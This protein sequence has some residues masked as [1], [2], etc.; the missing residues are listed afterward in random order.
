MTV[1]PEAPPLGRV[2]NLAPPT[3]EEMATIMRAQAPEEAA[4]PTSGAGMTTADVGQAISKATSAPAPVMPDTTDIVVELPAG[5][6]TPAGLLVDTARCRELN[7]FDEEKLSR[8]DPMKNSAVYVTELLSLGVDDLGGEKP[9]KDVLRSLLIGDRD[10]LMLGVRRATYG[11]EVEFKLACNVC[12]NDSLIKVLIDEDVPVTRLDDPVVREFEVALRNGG[13]AMVRLLNGEAQEAFSGD[14]GKKTQAELTTVMLAKSV[15]AING[16]PVMGRTED[17]LML[18]AA[19]R[20]T[21]TDFIAEHQP[22]PQLNKEIPVSCS[23]CGQEYPVLLGL[24]N[25]FRF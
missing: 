4:P 15:V 20:Q 8:V 2:P 12:D 13:H 7:G 10:A 22:G 6:L 23:V 11:N 14:A 18:S 9:T 24:P 25:L 5:W 17:V 3:P 19:D 16:K 1:Q 21:I